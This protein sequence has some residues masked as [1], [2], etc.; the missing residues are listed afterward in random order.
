MNP[1]KQI[2]KTD[3][4]PYLVEYSTDDLKKKNK[5]FR[6]FLNGHKIFIK[7]NI[8]SNPQ[9]KDKDPFS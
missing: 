2:I 1:R 8:E 4:C 5:S 3:P 6:Y 7:N 9:D